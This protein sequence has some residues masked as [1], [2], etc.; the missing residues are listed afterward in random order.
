VGQSQSADG[1][2]AVYLVPTDAA[3]AR[4]ITLHGTVDGAD[5]LELVGRT[6]YVTDPQGVVEIALS[7]ALT[8]GRVI[9]TTTVPGAA[10]PSAAKAFT[11][12][13]STPTSATTTPTSATPSPPSRWPPSP[14]RDAQV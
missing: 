7:Q 4:R 8:D 12:T 10:W 14:V 2:S 1:H 5:G 13:R 6:L 11:Y 9:G 3:G